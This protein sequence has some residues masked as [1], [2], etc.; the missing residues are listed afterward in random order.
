M[1]RDIRIKEEVGN[2]YG[3]LV[4]VEYTEIDKPGAYWKCRCD[5]GGN[6]TV[7]AT[8]LRAGEALSC[9][10]LPRET[11]QRL[12]SARKGKLSPTYIHGNKCGMHS[13]ARTEFNRGLELVIII[14]ARIAARRRRKRWQISEKVWPSIILMATTMITGMRMRL[15]FVKFATK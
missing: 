10:C 6:V 3:R 1:L 12:A 7:R 2:R 5:C 15:R 13:V 9:G 11:I 8:H 4:V 14:L